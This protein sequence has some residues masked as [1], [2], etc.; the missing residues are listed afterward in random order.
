VKRLLSRFFGLQPGDGPL[1]G[2]LFA[3]LFLVITSYQMGKAAR[4]ALFLSA[5]QASKL[6]Y[7][8]MAI[9]LTVGA[10]FALYVTIGRRVAVRN[11]VAGSLLVF[12]GITCGFWYLARH[13]PGLAWLFP[14]FY[15]WVGILGVLAPTQ[16]WTLANYLMTTRQAKR[17]FG[18]VGAGGITGWVF[19]GML[20][21]A[22]ASREGLGTESLLFAMA[23]CFT[24]CAGIVL[25]LWRL[26]EGGGPAE[27]RVEEPASQSL[28]SSLRVIF[29]SPYL[30]A[31]ASLITLSS[32][33]TTFAGWQFKAI[34]KIAY[35]DKD[36][37]AAFFGVFNFWVGLACLVLQLLLTSRFLRRFGLG[38]ALLVVPLALFGGEI[39]VFALGTLTTAIFLKGADQ[40]LRYSLDKS[41]V[42]LLYLP[43]PQ[44]IKLQAKSCIDTFIWRLGDGIAGFTLAIFTDQLRWSP[45][46]V[47]VVN[48][49]FLTLWIAAAIIARRQYA[50]N[51]LDS[52]RRRRLDARR[53]IAPVLD[54][55][56]VEVLAERL[57]SEDPK[58]VLYAL[59]IFGVAQSR[60]THPAIRDL[61]THESPAVRGA[62]IARLDQVGDSWALPQVEKLLRDE[63]L[64]VRTAA[65]LFLAHHSHVDPLTRVEGLRDFPAYSISSAMV[66]FLSQ[67]GKGE[68]LVTARLL[69]DQMVDQ[70]GPEGRAARKEAA[71]LL[72]ML[73]DQFEKPLERLLRDD[74]PEVVRQAMATVARLGKRSMAPLLIAGLGDGRIRDEA[75]AAL[76]TLGDRVVGTLRDALVDTSLEDRVRFE[77]PT[78]LA[79]IASRAAANALLERLLTAEADLRFRV[80]SALN[81]LQRDH[82]QIELDRRLLHA[83]LA[84]ETMLH[85]R[86]NQIAALIANQDGREEREG[87]THRVRERIENDR[88]AEIERIFRLLGLLHP[89]IDFHTAHFGLCSDDPSER[90]NSL[91]FLDLT[92]EPELRKT[93]VPLL[94]P[95]ATAADRIAPLLRHTRMEVPSQTDLVAAMIESNDAWLQVCALSAIGSIGLAGFAE[96]VEALLGSTDELLRSAALAAKQRLAAS[97]D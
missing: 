95:A 22:L 45:Q 56:T 60:S 76:V 86:T 83:T 1:G 69:V 5:Y 16:V 35:E 29:S 89:E 31:I 77:I 78:V 87:P 2:L 30:I 47:S 91:E 37:L 41:S 51:L 96:E 94:D 85:C 80:I 71:E 4:D 59:E 68:N 12:A 61:L 18:L 34:A 32:V 92:L 6:P 38:P 73:P 97:A 11:L 39:A 90:D 84:F 67:P 23:V 55:S 3:Y 64:G 17:V 9:A 65:L 54:R 21:K 19:A 70:E 81:Q 36:A 27:T 43:I 14:A 42:E 53:Q 28:S 82:P 52:I 25:A 72:G 10:V 63:D 58:E 74:E 79:A 50:V 20:T 15:L 62:A 93:L 44:R 66:A 7:A 75:S 24:V 88:A 46:R 26:R 40:L 8:D 57:S 49:G 48:L 33:A 13:H